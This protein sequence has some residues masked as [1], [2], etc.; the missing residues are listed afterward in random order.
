M[1]IYLQNIQQYKVR[2]TQRLGHNTKDQQDTIE[3]DTGNLFIIDKGYQH[4][5]YKGSKKYK[6]ETREQSIKRYKG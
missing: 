6:K 4:S 3:Q 5:A 2:Q 1:V